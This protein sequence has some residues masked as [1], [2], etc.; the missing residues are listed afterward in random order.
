MPPDTQLCLYCLTVRQPFVQFIILNWKSGESRG[1]Y[2]TLGRLENRYILLH[3]AKKTAKK[4]AEKQQA[5]ALQIAQ[6]RNLP[7]SEIEQCLSACDDQHTLGH[8]VAIVRLGR[9]TKLEPKNLDT[10]ERRKKW[11]NR[12]FVPATDLEG[13]YVTQITEVH[14][15]QTPWPLRGSQSKFRAQVSVGQLPPKLDH[16]ILKL[17]RLP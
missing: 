5:S 1:Q 17:S 3:V 15:I 7:P 8:V 9:T 14:P 10:E 6:A 2:H 13:M 16:K 12:T 11:E 4:E